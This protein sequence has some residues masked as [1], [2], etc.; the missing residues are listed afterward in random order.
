MA[1]GVRDQDI[2]I[3]QISNGVGITDVLEPILVTSIIPRGNP[4]RNTDPIRQLGA[5][6]VALPQISRHRGTPFYESLS[7]SFGSWN[8]NKATFVPS[9]SDSFYAV[10]MGDEYRLD[11]ISN[12]LYN[13]A[14]FWWVIA[15]VNNI[16]NPFKRPEVGEL[17]RVPSLERILITLR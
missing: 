8:M 10:P 7:S 6:A 1:L 17:L 15:V 3:R 14:F 13:T 2:K 12:R 9:E 16:R 11:I 4:L 5:D